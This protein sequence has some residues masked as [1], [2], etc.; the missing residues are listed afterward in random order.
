MKKKRWKHLLTTFSGK[1]RMIRLLDISRL[2][3]AESVLNVQIPSYLVEVSYI[4]FKEIPPL[5]D[6]A[7]TLAACGETFLGFFV[8]EELAGFLSY[9]MDEDIMTICRVAV[10]PEHFKKG[11]ASALLKEAEKAAYSV[12]TIKVSTGKKNSPAISLYQKTGYS[13]TKDILI[14]PDLWITCLEKKV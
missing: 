1:D 11:I 14:Q 13:K 3:I 5:K 7:E 2:E 12:R 8:K 9:E 4:G 6:T 10:H